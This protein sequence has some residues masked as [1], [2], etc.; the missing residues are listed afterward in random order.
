M[1]RSAAQL[2]ALL[3]GARAVA[4]V[5]DVPAAT[6][7]QAQAVG[8]GWQLSEVNDTSSRPVSTT[9]P[10]ATTGAPALPSTTATPFP[11]FSLLGGVFYLNL[12]IDNWSMLGTLKTEWR[13]LRIQGVPQIGH[14]AVTVD[15]HDWTFATSNG[16][17]NIKRNLTMVEWGVAEDCSYTGSNMSVNLVGTPFAFQPTYPVAV[18]AEAFGSVSCGAGSQLCVGTCGGWCGHCGLGSA[19]G[20]QSAVLQVVNQPQFDEALQSLYSLLFGAVQTT[21][22]TTTTRT[23]TT[24]TRTTTSTRTTTRTTTRTATTTTTTQ[25]AL[26][27]PSKERAAVEGDLGGLKAMLVLAVATA[28]GVGLCVAHR[29]GMLPGWLDKLRAYSSF[30][31]DADASTASPGGGGPPPRNIGTPCAPKPPPLPSWARKLSGGPREPQDPGV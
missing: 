22:V 16:Q 17:I 9:A 8:E 10:A 7:T 2:A 15:L 21:T 12:P 20:T 26:S 3:V 24:T 18:G 31:E 29:R 25:T 4:A 30:R 19:G 23:A 11:V 13:A 6:S 28:A 14:S 27:I 1:G 5:P